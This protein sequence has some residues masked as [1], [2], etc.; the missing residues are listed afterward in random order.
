M[1]I[2]VTGGA[3]FI[4]STLVD[5]LVTEHVVGVIDDL[6]SGKRSQVH[7]HAWFRELD[8]TSPALEATV[9]E[10]APNAVVHLAA[11]PNVGASFKDP[12]RDW[13]VNA[14]G[15]RRVAAA[16]AASGAQVMVSASSAAVYGDP[17]GA[18]L[19]LA[20]TAQKSP[21]SPYGSSKLAAEEMI[22][23]ELSGTEM[24]FASL[25]FSNV[26]G[27]RQDWQGEGGVVAIF[28]ASLAAGTP[29]TIFGAGHQTRD[30]IFV[31]DVVEAVRCALVS[32]TPLRMGEAGGPAYNIS[33]GRQTSV[34]TLGGQLRL[35]SHFNGMFQYAA[36]REGDIVYSALDPAKARTVFGWDARVPLDQGL[37]RTYAYFSGHAG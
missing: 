8:I 6:S 25:R 32:P 26:Y 4:G 3:G 7:A 37:E 9:S 2:L 33:T 18:K 1:R 12:Q 10:F 35:L 19:P 28:C 16:A 13:L 20:E 23:A 24:D 14:E 5:A 31:G 27:P 29:P 30:F 22:A 15:T 21:T 36:E 34:E 11:Q 17:G